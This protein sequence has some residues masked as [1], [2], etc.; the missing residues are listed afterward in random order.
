VSA[1]ALERVSALELEQALEL[2]SVL[3]SASASEQE[4]ERVLEQALEQE[5]VL[6]LELDP[7]TRKYRSCCSALWRDRYSSMSPM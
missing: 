5:S 2:V 7:L 6:V 4:L 1:L 3:G